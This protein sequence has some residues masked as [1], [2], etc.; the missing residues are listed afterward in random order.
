VNTQAP[1]NPGEEE[2]N[3]AGGGTCLDRQMD[4]SVFED[5]LAFIVGSR[6]AR[7]R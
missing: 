2:I 6:I 1:Q 4:R 7:A 3:W 5:S